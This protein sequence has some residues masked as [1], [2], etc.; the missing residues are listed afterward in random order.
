MTSTYIA[1]IGDG[2]RITLEKS[3]LVKEG[4]A[5]GDFVEL[6]VRKIEKTPKSESGSPYST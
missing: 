1:Q 4:L 5:L 6:T 2:Y 3:I